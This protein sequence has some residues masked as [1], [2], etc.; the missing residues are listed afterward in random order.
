METRKLYY[1]DTHIRAFSAKVVSCAKADN[2]WE[3]LLDATAFYPEGGGQACDLGILGGRTV[4]D[5]QER[6]GKIVHLCDAPLEIGATVEGAID[7]ER[8]FNLMQQ[9]TGEHIVSGIIN[10]WYGYHNVG[11]HMGSEMTEIDFDGVIPAEDLASIEREANAALWKN[12]PVKCWYPSQEEL[13]NVFYRTKRALPWPVRIVEVPGYDSCACCGIHVAHTGEVGLVKLFSVVGLRGGSRIEMS[14]GKRALMLLNR[15]FEQNKQVSQAFSAKWPETGEAARKMNEALAN[16]KYR[17]AG[18][19]KRIFEIIAKGY[20]DCGNVVHFEDGLES[21]EVRMLANAIAEICGGM[22]AVFSGADGEGYGFAMVT[23]DG[24][25]RPVGK[26]MTAAL[27]GRGGGK[28][29]YQQGRVQATKQ[30]IE[31]F[32]EEA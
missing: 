3:I 26:K 30:Q 5:V 12:L 19:Q 29:N 32:F 28:P 24:D 16:E 18:L 6:D 10:R 17:T 11:F 27:H 23:R 1:E 9:H 22:A 8:R 4:L 13:P 21:A 2:G 25:L 14:C 15:A 31:A 20:V 7:Y